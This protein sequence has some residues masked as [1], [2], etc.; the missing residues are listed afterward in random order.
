MSANV[1]RFI[2][3]VSIDERRRAHDP[4][5]TGREAVDLQWALRRAA[6]LAS[7]LPFPK[8]VL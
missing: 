5:A 7:W 3:S 4:A 8:R 2:A 1:I 6:K